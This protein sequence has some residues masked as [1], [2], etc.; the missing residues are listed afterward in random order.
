MGMFNDNVQPRRLEWEYEY[1][2]SQ[3]LPH[4]QELLHLHTTKEREAREKTADLL[5]DVTVSQ[6]DTRFAE[7]KREITSHGTLKEQC[8]VFVHEFERYPGRVFSLG[9]GDVTFFGLTTK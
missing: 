7:L 1:S 3:L 5:R 6:N 2:G 4:A 8:E 9:L